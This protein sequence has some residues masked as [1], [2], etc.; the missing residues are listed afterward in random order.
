MSGGRHGL[1][2]YYFYISW[3]PERHR[4]SMPIWR[5]LVR[6]V[7]GDIETTIDLGTMNDLFAGVAVS[8]FPMLR[9]G[10]LAS[11]SNVAGA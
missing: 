10:I 6:P 8:D 11:R 1:N 3:P 9:G 5:M 2:Y 7:I 4:F